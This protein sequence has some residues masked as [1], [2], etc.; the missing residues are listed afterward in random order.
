MKQRQFSQEQIVAILHQA[1]KGEITIQALCKEH[2]TSEVTFYRWRKAYGGM[3]TS[4]ASKLKQLE[5]E[6]ARL[7]RLL[8]ERDLALDALQEFLQKRSRQAGA[9][10][11]P[12]LPARERTLSTRDLSPAEAQS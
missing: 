10:G 1:E 9:Q 4:E 5:K 11:N 12:R 3:T 7:K 6:N 2:C 8:A